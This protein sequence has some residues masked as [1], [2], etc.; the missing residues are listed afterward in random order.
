MKKLLILSILA[1]GVIAGCKKKDSL[2]S[3]VVTVSYPTVTITSGQYFSFPVGGGPL[4]SANS[5][6]ATAYDSFYRQSLP[7]VVDA[8]TLTNLSPG[9]YIATVSAKNK[10]GFVGYNYVYVAITNVSDTMDLSGLYWRAG[11]PGGN[12]SANPA[13]VY[14]LARG[15]Y[16][17]D[18][19]G[20]VDTGTQKASVIPAVFAVT[21][22]ST[23]DFGTQMTKEGILTASPAS[24]NMIVAD[25]TLDYAIN[26]S[27]FGSQLRTFVKK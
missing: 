25:T 9:L 23:L 19:V 4:P 21:S 17:T 20:G 1:V 7:V 18:N 27:G 6:T 24:L 11:V 16:M 22:L 8:S 5:I 2:V 26:L 3:Q 10:Y 12:D 13:N 15:L 14:K